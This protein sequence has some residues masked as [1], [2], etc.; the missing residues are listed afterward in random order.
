MSMG[1]SIGAYADCV[2]AR[3][4]LGEGTKCEAVRSLQAVFQPGKIAEAAYRSEEHSPPRLGHRA[5]GSR[6]APNPGE[7]GRQ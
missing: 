4:D 6:R 1:A 3:A 5:L 2:V 7:P